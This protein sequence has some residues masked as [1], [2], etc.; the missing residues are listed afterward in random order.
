MEQQGNISRRKI[1]C[2]LIPVQP[3]YL[4]QG[5]YPPLLFLLS[6]PPLTTASA[7]TS[8]SST[9]TTTT[10]TT[11]SATTTNSVG[12]NIV[13]VTPSVVA[14]PA[15]RYDSFDPLTCD[16]PH[17][18]S[19]SWRALGRPRI[20]SPKAAD[21]VGR[22]STKRDVQA[23]T[24]RDPRGRGGVSSVIF[25][26]ATWLQACQCRRRYTIR[27]VVYGGTTMF[28]LSWTVCT[29]GDA[30]D[31]L[32]VSLTRTVRRSFCD[33]IVTASLREEGTERQRRRKCDVRRSWFYRLV[34]THV[35]KW[36]I[37]TR[38]YYFIVC[39]IL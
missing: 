38:D 29:R 27:I 23:R 17:T 32:L 20:R 6:I 34:S 7:T 9:T 35:L 28:Q 31:R 22:L 24:A 36:E 14:R 25:I 21:D 37:Y 5:T 10:T 30:T 19:R 4:F 13:V 11:I 12:I 1:L 39:R 2:R 15:R 26:Q 33:F 18:A 16:I 8:S 3:S